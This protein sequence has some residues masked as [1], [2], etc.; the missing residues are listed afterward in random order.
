MW[1]GRE[2]AKRREVYNIY[3]KS[4]KFFKK[5]ERDIVTKSSR[6]KEFSNREMETRFNNWEKKNEINGIYD[7]PSFKKQQNF[8]KLDGCP[9]RY[10]C[11]KKWEF[12]QSIPQTK[13][14]D[15]ADY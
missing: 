8:T 3:K 10:E 15:L 9:L 14:S 11:L 12:V 5:K 7:L 1:M 6:K 13:F 2:V 4:R